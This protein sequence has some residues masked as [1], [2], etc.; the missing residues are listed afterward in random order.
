[1]YCNICYNICI[2]A[3][4]T[5]HHSHLSSL[6]ASIFVSSF[7]TGGIAGSVMAGYVAD[8]LVAMVSRPF[9][10]TGH[11]GCQ[12]LLYPIFSKTSYTFQY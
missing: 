1:M 9:A 8:K 12:A 11:A 4:A 3:S 5:A 7:E 2:I 10:I 6:S